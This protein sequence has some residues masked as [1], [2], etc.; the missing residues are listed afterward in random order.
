MLAGQIE[1]H[2]AA[3]PLATENIP[4]DLSEK[5]K[6]VLMAALA[7]NASHL[8]TGDVTHFGR[9]YGRQIEGLIILLPGEYLKGNEGK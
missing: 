9:Y 7:M 2:A 1:I 4:D 5:D 8:L 3:G 6:P